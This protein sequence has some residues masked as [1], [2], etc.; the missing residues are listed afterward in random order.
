MDRFKGGSPCP[1]RC[2]DPQEKYAEPEPAVGEL[3]PP[4]PRLGLHRRLPHA[5]VF[6]QPLRTQ[7]QHPEQP[8]DAVHNTDNQYEEGR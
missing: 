8:Q 4:T 5:R 1:E 3:I 2:R 7:T 6:R